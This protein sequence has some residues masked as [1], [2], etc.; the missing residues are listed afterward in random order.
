MKE[1][2]SYSAIKVYEKC[3]RRFRKSREA[4]GKTS[5][6]EAQ[7]AGK[8]AHA[9]MAD[10]I[11][12]QKPTGKAKTDAFVI[13]NLGLQAKAEV[14]FDLNVWGTKIIGSIDAVSVSGNT[15]TIVDWKNRKSSFV[16]VEQLKLYAFALP[17]L[18]NNT[19]IENFECFFFY[20]ATETY[21]HFS[22]NKTDMDEY[23]GE[24]VETLEKISADKDFEPI[25]G[26]HCSD[27]SWLSDC[28]IAKGYG[29]TPL[30]GGSIE[31]VRKE[32][33]KVFM[34]DALVSDAKVRIK[35][36]MI[37]NGVDE[38]EINDKDRYYLYNMPTQ[39][40]E[41]KIAK[42]KGEVAHHAV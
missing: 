10:C 2:V 11:K 38:I 30:N 17:R 27:C 28:P 25:A 14:S 42:K 29:I 39:L 35:E 21:D 12:N 18:M 3:P 1:H 26:S 34:I 9:K 23:L 24:L 40:K 16:D 19:A 8:I 20:L 6:N 4:D 7:E 37:E 41:G 15:A 31:L 5:S 36:W 22:F 13:R 32:L 33:E